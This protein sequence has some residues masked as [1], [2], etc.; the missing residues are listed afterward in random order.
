MFTKNKKI[1]LIV[2]ILFVIF[3]QIIN[4]ESDKKYQVVLSCLGLAIIL[5]SFIINKTNK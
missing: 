2:I 4:Y 5:L 1:Y 3:M